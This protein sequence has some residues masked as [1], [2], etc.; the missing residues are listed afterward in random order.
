MNAVAPGGTNTDMAVEHGGSYRH[1]AVTSSFAE[2][3]SS[4]IALERMGEADEVA[5]AYAFLASPGATYITG[6]T[7]PVDGGM[8]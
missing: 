4:S 2:W 7:I 8:F 1:P 5:G 3:L 6:R